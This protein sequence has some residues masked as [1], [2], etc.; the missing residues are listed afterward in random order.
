MWLVKRGSRPLSVSALN[1]LMQDLYQELKESEA[2]MGILVHYDCR[3]RF[4][5]PRTRIDPP[6]V[7]AAK[8]LRSSIDTAFDWKNF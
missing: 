2:I 5:D 4:I 1:K 7:P 3:R 6:E 8:T